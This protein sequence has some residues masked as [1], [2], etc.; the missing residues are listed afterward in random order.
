MKKII[1]FTLAALLSFPLFAQLEIQ[2]ISLNEAIAKA[3]KENKMVMIMVSTTWCGPCKAITQETFPLKEVGDAFNDKLILLKYEID[4]NDPEGI[5]KKYDISRYPTFL[6]IDAEGKDHFSVTKAPRGGKP[7]IEMVNEALKPENG[8]SARRAKFDNDISTGNEYVSFLIDNMN[9]KLANEVMI[10]LLNKRT[11][12]ENFNETNIAFYPKWM[13]S[14]FNSPV[15]KYILKHSDEIFT[16]VDKDKIYALTSQTI[17]KSLVSLVNY[18]KLDHEKFKKSLSMINGS[19]IVK[20]KF[21]ELMEVNC[22]SFLNNDYHAIMELAL[23]NVESVPSTDREALIH[24]LK[25]KVPEE[26]KEEYKKNMIA[27]YEK[28]IACEKIELNKA[29]YTHYLK[30][31]NK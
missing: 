31:L 29:F 10:E 24:Y 8:W 30:S 17:N 15:L 2:K 11:V 27:V 14:N 16:I 25:S 28:A 3:K 20:S 18:P 26:N 6:F 19:P 21:S 4:V 22:D 5:G 13:G 23:K 12:T 9:Y 7:F 1:L